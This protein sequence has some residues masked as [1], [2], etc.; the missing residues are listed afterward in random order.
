MSKKHKLWRQYFFHKYLFGCLHCKKER[1]YYTSKYKFYIMMVDDSCPLNVSLRNFYVF[2]SNLMKLV[3]VVVCM[4]YYKFWWKTK[5]LYITHSTD[6]PPVKGRWIRPR[7]H[8]LRIASNAFWY[9]CSAKS[10]SRDKIWICSKVTPIPVRSLPLL[11]L[12]NLRPG[13]KKMI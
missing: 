3:E 13:R 1:K 5:F 10:Y 11:Q 6:S 7:T 4:E 2:Q 12:V 9:S 8:Y